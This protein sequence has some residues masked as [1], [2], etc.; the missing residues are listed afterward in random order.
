MVA[1][2]AAGKA[3][4]EQL[5]LGGRTVEHHLRDIFS[6]LGIRS[7]VELVRFTS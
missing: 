3:V 1:E 5:F 6:K 2:G 4:A 7:R